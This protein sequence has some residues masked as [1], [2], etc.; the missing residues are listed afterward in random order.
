MTHAGKM[1]VVSL[2]TK[3]AIKTSCIVATNTWKVMVPGRM[4]V[5]IFS[6]QSALQMTIHLL[7][8]EFSHKPCHLVLFHLRSSSPSTVTVYG[9]DSR[10]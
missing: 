1:L 6:T 9:G 3:G 4:Q 5:K 7:I 8:M 2:V 10:I